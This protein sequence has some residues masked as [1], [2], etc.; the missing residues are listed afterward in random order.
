MGRPLPPAN[1]LILVAPASLL[2]GCFFA[3]STILDRLRGGSKHRSDPC[4]SVE[5]EDGMGVPHGMRLIQPAPHHG[6]GS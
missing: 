1:M 6:A 2:S 3:T 4:L 5:R